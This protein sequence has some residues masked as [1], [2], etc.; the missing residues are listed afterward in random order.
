MCVVLPNLLS[1]EGT[2]VDWT[3]LIALSGFVQGRAMRHTRERPRLVSVTEN[4]SNADV[5]KSMG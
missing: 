3:S 1:E 2:A 5:D 4:F